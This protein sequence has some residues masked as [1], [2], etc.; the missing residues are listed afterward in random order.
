[1]MMMNSP[2]FIDIKPAL[3][4]LFEPG[5]NLWKRKDSKDY[6]SMTALNAVRKALRLPKIWPPNGDSDDREK[7]RQEDF[8]STI[9]GFRKILEAIGIAGS[10]KVLLKKWICDDTK[11]KL[12]S[13]EYLNSAIVHGDLNARNLTWSGGLKSFFMID[14]EHVGPQFRGI[15]QFRLSINLVVDLMGE[16][17][18]EISY[19]ELQEKDHLFEEIDN[20]IKF[21]IKLSNSLVKG[22]SKNLKNLCIDVLNELKSEKPDKK[23][24]CKL[25][26]LLKAIICSI[27]Y[28][29]KKNKKEWSRFWGYVLF[30]TALKEYE[31]SSRSVNEETVLKI[32]NSEKPNIINPLTY[33]SKETINFLFSN[34]NIK[35]AQREIGY[36][37]RYL[38]AIKILC[39]VCGLQS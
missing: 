38:T 3:I 25:C 9:D 39:S 2:K 19:E 1:M 4:E 15:D 28:D 14:F 8:K 37:F 22:T 5:L 7:R 34:P 17:L 10:D 6:E 32:L 23:D 30:C 20:G 16:A 13:P 29:V 26:I 11:Y 35:D 24:E 36:Y 12:I 21:L 33:N 18:T 31:Y 27:K